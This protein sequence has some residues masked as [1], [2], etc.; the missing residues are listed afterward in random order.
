MN[1]DIVGGDTTPGDKLADK[2]LVRV[3][4]EGVPSTATADETRRL[5]ALGLESDS[6]SRELARAIVDVDG[7]YFAR[8]SSASR[9]TFRPVLEMRLDRYLRG[10]RSPFLQ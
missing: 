10:G 7:S 3:F 4:S 6:P 2:A 9:Q 1:N 5:L 8:D